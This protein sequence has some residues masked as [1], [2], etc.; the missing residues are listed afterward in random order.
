M[1]L[2]KN[3]KHQAILVRGVDMNKVK[4]DAIDVKF[5]LIGMAYGVLVVAIY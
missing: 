1:G 5:T 3:T 2:V 4:K